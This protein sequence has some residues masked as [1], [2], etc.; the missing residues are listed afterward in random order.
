MFVFFIIVAIAILLLMVVIHEY[1]HYCAGKLLGFKILEFSVGFGPKI[2]QR[3]LKNGEKFTLRMIP[4]G[5]YC[6]FFDEEGTGDGSQ[7]GVK[8]FVQHS[9]LHRMIVFVSGALFNFVSAII[10]ALIFIFVSGYSVPV[11]N[12]LTPVLENPNQNYAT[13]LKLNDIIVGVNDRELG[14]MYT[15]N[16]AMNTVKGDNVD[17]Y[18]TVVRD[19]NYEKITVRRQE[20][21]VLDEQNNVQTYQGFG[22]VPVY[23]KQSVNFFDAVA[24]CVPLTLKFSWMI[25]GAFGSMLTG[26][27]PLTQMTGPISTVTSIASFA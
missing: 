24:N 7:N 3:T 11:V 27:V 17:F 20:I 9:P 23:Q 14:V 25:L 19:G 13:E 16:D 12:E 4:L 1:G 10:F 26:Q 5:G 18:L 22:F 15:W 2:L 8:S 21:S 6:A